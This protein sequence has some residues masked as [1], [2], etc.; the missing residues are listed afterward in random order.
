MAT[1]G[2][3]LLRFDYSYSVVAPAKARQGQ[4]ICIPYSQSRPS[5]MLAQ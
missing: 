4:R 5:L 2:L 1:S 3:L